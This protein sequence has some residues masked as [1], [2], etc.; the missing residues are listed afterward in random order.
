MLLMNSFSSVLKFIEQNNSMVSWCQWFCHC[1]GRQ[2]W[3][4]DVDNLAT[5]WCTLKRRTQKVDRFWFI[6]VQSDESM[7]FY[8]KLVQPAVATATTHGRRHIDLISCRKTVIQWYNGSIPFQHFVLR[9]TGSDP[10]SGSS[11]WECF[12]MYAQLL[13]Q[14]WF[15]RFLFV[16]YIWIRRWYRLFHGEEG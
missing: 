5:V 7:I 8:R 16:V 10:L 3:L 12:I 9:W 4:M 14:F 15:V 2:K 13:H 1:C 11:F 6:S